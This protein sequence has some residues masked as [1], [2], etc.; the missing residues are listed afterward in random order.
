[1]G[2]E[3]GESIACSEVHESRDPPDIIRSPIQGYQQ[4]PP[5]PRKKDQC[6]P[7]LKTFN[8]IGLMMDFRGHTEESISR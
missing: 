3:S 8:E 4:T 7:K 6:S 5:P 2:G 1:M